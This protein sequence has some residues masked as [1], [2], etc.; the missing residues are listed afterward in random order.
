MTERNA[1]CA[2]ALDTA[3]DAYR[4]GGDFAS[5]LE[6]I[7]RLAG[8]TSVDDLIL[9][10]QPYLNVPEVTG[11]IYEHVVAAR[12]ND[13][14]ALV[15]LAGAY[16]LTGRGPEVVGELASRAISLNALNRGAWHLWALVEADQRRRMERWIQV[17]TRFPE[18]E[19]AK[20][21]LA[22]NAISLANAEND[23]VALSIA[24]NSY[25]QLLV[26]AKLP[27]QREALGKALATLREW[28][29]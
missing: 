9:A 25:E 23:P 19:L 22:D 15:V 8:V 24:V 3:V 18:D 7:A 13:D 11:P 20:A 26:Q 2:S 16:W 28:R 21:N 10:A 17:V 1:T 27:E 6:E 14:R 29:L 4:N 12:P 5:L